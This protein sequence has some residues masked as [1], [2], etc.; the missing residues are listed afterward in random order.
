MLAGFTIY[1]GQRNTAALEAVYQDSVR[2]L[3]QLQRI[4]SEL[5]EIR[6]RAAGVLLDLM[7]VQGSLNQLREVRPALEKSWADL[8]SAPATTD[9][10]LQALRSAM[11]SGWP[12]VQAILDKLEAAYSA[13]DTKRLSDILESE[14]PQGHK[15]FVKPLQKVIPLEEDR[16]KNTYDAAAKDNRRFS[17]IAASLA[18]AFLAV[19]VAAMFLTSR[20]VI[21]SLDKAVEVTRR[22]AAGDLSHQ[23]PAHRDDEVGLLLAALGQMQQALSTIVSDIRLTTTNISSASRQI[24]AGSGELSSRTEQAAS[25]LQQTAASMEQM[26]GSVQSS[27]H[28]AKQANG[29]VL[30]ASQVAQQGGEAMSKVVAT[31]SEIHA[32]S[33]QIA[34]IISVID[35]I[36]FQTNILA[37][38]AA[39]EAAR[40]GEQ[41]R[42]FAVVASEV[43]ALAQRSAAAAK[44]VRTLIASSA[45]R[46]DQGSGLVGDT[47]R[48][49]ENVVSQVQQI[50]ELVSAITHAAAEQSSG[51]AQV[52]Q[53]VTDM[54]HLTQQNAAL[55]EQSA[56]AA[57]ALMSLAAQ[58]EKTIAV[59]RLGAVETD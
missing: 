10:E 30:S 23:I 37:L 47:G 33:R 54:D 22:I 28:N 24:V 45:S 52:G 29:I 15:A 20:Y 43:R 42:G 40:A 11:E 18:I 25:S 49:I 12:V 34:D 26:T 44:E 38:N 56:A 59:F 3:V 51:I 19:V 57:E 39:V 14:W 16:A 8:R 6:F 48:T 35:G 2:T 27:A 32:S 36:S 5:R 58:L 50:S 13:K 31:M 4:D 1:S 9:A 41:G 55:A 21:R 17:A 53:A 7:P 46:V